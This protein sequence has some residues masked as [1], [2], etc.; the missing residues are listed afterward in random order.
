MG[1]GGEDGKRSKLGLLAD[2]YLDRD[3]SMNAV[4]LSLVMLS[5]E[6]LK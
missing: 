5:F 6:A 1:V 4:P 2:Q 3:I